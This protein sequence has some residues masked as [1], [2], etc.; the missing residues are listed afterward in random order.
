MP[1]IILSALPPAAALRLPSVADQV[2]EGLYDRIVSLALAPGTRLS[3]S[4]VAKVF[5]VSR[6][7]VRDAFWRLSKL[8]FL[9]IRPQ[10]ATLVAG[11]SKPQCCRRDSCGRRSRSRRCGSPP[12]ASSTTI[13]RR[14]RH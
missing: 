9:T 1:E 8:G 12:A 4:E 7:P 5:D 10:R 3:E 6:Q 11:I 2:F 13:S 14:S